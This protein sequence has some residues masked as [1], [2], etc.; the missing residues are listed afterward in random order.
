MSYGLVNGKVEC[1]KNLLQKVEMFHSKN[2]NL[3]KVSMVKLYSHKNK[4]LNLIGLWVS[5]IPIIAMQ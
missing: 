2:I 1:V 3:L 4:I 5:R